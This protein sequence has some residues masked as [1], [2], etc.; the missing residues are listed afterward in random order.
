M[1]KGNGK[2][3]KYDGIQILSN[4]A[5]HFN[6]LGTKKAHPAKRKYINE[7][8][9]LWIFMHLEKPTS[10]IP[11]KNLEKKNPASF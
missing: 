6:K 7:C 10:P 4:K 1:F 11:R 2:R 8:F 3:R 9:E 5:H